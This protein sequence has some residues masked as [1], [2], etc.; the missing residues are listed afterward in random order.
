MIEPY[1]A[2]WQA[3]TRC[4]GTAYRHP[5]T[6]PAESHLRAYQKTKAAV[7]ACKTCRFTVRNVPFR[8]AKR[9]VS[10]AKTARFVTLLTVNELQRAHGA[11]RRVSKIKGRLRQGCGSDP[12]TAAAQQPPYA[13]GKNAYR[14][15]R[16]NRNMNVRILPNWYGKASTC[17]LLFQRRGR[18]GLPNKLIYKV[19]N[20]RLC[21]CSTNHPRHSFGKGGDNALRG[22]QFAGI[23]QQKRT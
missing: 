16:K 20:H 23:H 9:A 5:A 14:P 10:Q 15:L 18:G 1:S 13:P 12:G 17:P 2:F 3:A 8:D 4:A 22:W 19:F 11:L 7:S 6:M 21:H